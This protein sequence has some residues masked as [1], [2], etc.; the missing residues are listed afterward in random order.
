MHDDYYYYYYYYCYYYLVFFPPTTIA[1][2]TAIYY[3]TH[4]THT[5]HTHDNNV[6]GQTNWNICYYTLYIFTRTHTHAYIYI[7]IYNIY[8]G[9]ALGTQLWHRIL[10][11][12]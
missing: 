1:H 4:D 6:T 10:S 12:F 3:P 9:T 11:P 7:Y 8:I 2:D 5:A